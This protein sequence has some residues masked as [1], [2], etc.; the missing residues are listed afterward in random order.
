[1][2]NAALDEI[3]RPPGAFRVDQ[4][5]LRQIVDGEVSALLP[6]AALHDVLKWDARGLCRR[7]RGPEGL[8]RR[9]RNAVPF[10]EALVVRQPP[11]LAPQMPF[12]EM[13][14][15]VAGGGKGLGNRYLP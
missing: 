2:G 15:G 12:A 6:F 4:P 7:L 14:S 5:A 11:L 8:V 3:D 9:A 1:C 10:I 13:A